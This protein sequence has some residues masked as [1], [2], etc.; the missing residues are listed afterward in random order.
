MQNKFLFNFMELKYKNYYNN[1]W[2]LCYGQFI[3]NKSIIITYK[4]NIHS[5][6]SIPFTYL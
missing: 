6:K 4:Y 5:Q 3:I 1:I 2:F